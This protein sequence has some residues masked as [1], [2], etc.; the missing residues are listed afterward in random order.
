MVE[1]GKVVLRRCDVVIINCHVAIHRRGVA[2]YVNGVMYQYYV[3]EESHNAGSA[4][5]NVAP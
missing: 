1:A 2:V 3:S 4:M 5:I